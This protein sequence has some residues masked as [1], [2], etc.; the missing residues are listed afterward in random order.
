VENC[1]QV[2]GRSAD[3]LQHIGG[4]R[5]LLKRFMKLP[6]RFSKLDRLLMKL[7]SQIVGRRAAAVNR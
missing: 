4:R 5:L 7:L 6:S 3:D 2:E 1:L